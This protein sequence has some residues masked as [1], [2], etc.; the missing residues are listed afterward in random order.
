MTEVKI[1]EDL[2]KEVIDRDLCTLCGACL[3]VCNANKVEAL[4]IE[5]N[6][7][8]YIAGG[9]DVTKKCLECGVCYLICGRIPKL[10]TEIEELYSVQPPLGSYKYLISARS[11]NPEIQKVAQDGGIV[12]TLLKYMMEKNLI[13]GV[14][15]NKPATN[16]VS[17]PQLITSI[18]ELIKS[19]GTRYTAIP[20]VQVLGDY[21][22]L[23]EENPRLAFVG[24]PCQVKA[25]RKMQALKA[26]PGVYVKYII[27]LFCMENFDYEKL[28]K[29][30]LEKEMKINLNDVQKVN[31]KGNFFIT[32]KN[33]KQI[34]IPLKDLS[35]LVRENCHYCDDFTNFYAD[36]SVGGIGSP[37]GYSTVLV[38][39][40][41]GSKLF[42]Q[43]MVENEIEALD[44]DT[45]Q[46][47]E[48]ILK[49]ITKLGNTKY[50]K[51]RESRAKLS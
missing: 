40:D 34:E 23:G 20:S 26:K 9:A 12:T 2:K 36:I 39:T 19:A 49:I 30:K 24:T 48:K 25:V 22:A 10:D 35:N 4:C 33:G 43:L 45:A 16:W 5:N 42:S 37:A 15:V 11:K 27:G 1:F 31:I 28:M 46:V 32:L 7:P 44:V 41:E 50:N 8:Q 29:E 13:D 47:H 6:K 38:R 17:G 3:S 51:G 21:G 14:V 18:D